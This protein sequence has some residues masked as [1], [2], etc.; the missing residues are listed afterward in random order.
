MVSPLVTVHKLNEGLS[1]MVFVKCK[2]L[3]QQNDCYHNVYNVIG[4]H[5]KYF[6][7]QEWKIAYG[8]LEIFEGLMCRHCFIVNKNYEVIDPSYPLFNPDKKHKVPQYWSF[9]I[10]TLDE[11][12]KNI[13][14]ANFMPCLGRLYRPLE[15]KIEAQSRA[16]GISI[17]A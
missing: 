2:H 7:T 9:K 4:S 10:F 15:E 6:R 1:E 14:D 12:T 11:Y 5:L 13:Q 16:E 3:L 17:I 8:Y